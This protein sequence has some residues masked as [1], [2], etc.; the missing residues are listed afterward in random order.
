M[1]IK[2]VDPSGGEIV[3]S[4]RVFAPKPW[5][6]SGVVPLKSHEGVASK[7]VGENCDGVSWVSKLNLHMERSLIPKMFFIKEYSTFKCLESRDVLIE[8]VGCER[9]RVKL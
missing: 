4:P 8:V 9:V 3:L 2:N 5:V 6:R 7:A 1:F